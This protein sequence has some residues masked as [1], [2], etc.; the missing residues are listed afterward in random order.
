VVSSDFIKEGLP[1]DDQYCY[2]IEEPMNLYYTLDGSEPTALSTPLTVPVAVA[3]GQQ[4]RFIAINGAASELGEADADACPAATGNLL[5]FAANQIQNN[6]GVDL[7]DNEDL[8]GIHLDDITAIGGSQLV[9]FAT[10]PNNEAVSWNSLTS[11]DGTLD[12]SGC[13][14]QTEVILSAL[15][16]TAASSTLNLYDCATMDTL[17]LSALVTIGASAVVDA[18]DNP[19]LVTPA[20]GNFTAGNNATIN[21][22]GCALD[23]AT[24]DHILARCVVNAG[25]VSGIVDLSGGTNAAPSVAGAADA[26]TL[27]GRGVTVTTN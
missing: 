20:L 4:F 10:C 13:P 21:F 18:Y 24:V 23:E 27:T 22:S 11:L 7:H 8:V 26:S 16:T 1:I 25:F 9:S 6:F 3:P 12:H 2:T 15:S 17:D 19:L 14:A 5:E